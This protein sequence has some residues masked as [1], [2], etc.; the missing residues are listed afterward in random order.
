MN[1]TT[2]QT[3]VDSLLPPDLQEPGRLLDGPGIK[4]LLSDVA[5]K[6]PEKYREISKNLADIGRQAAQ[7][8]GGFSFGLAHLKKSQYSQ[9]MCEA[10]AQDPSTPG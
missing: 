8:T 9:Q 1:F 2:G 6:H 4:K 5:V 7:E 10:A 3:L